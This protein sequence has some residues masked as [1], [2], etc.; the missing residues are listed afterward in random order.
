MSVIVEMNNSP[1]S[2]V[3]L[4]TALDASGASSSSPGSASQHSVPSNHPTP[5]NHSTPTSQRRFTQ[6]PSHQSSA[7]SEYVDSPRVFGSPL[8]ALHQ[9]SNPRDGGSPA[10]DDSS[11]L[12]YLRASPVTSSFQPAHSQGILPSASS[13]PGL[14]GSRRTLSGDSYPAESA[15]DSSQIEAG[16]STAPIRDGDIPR[17]RPRRR[18]SPLNLGHKDHSSGSGT[19]EEGTGQSRN[20][21]EH[22]SMSARTM[23]SDGGERVLR[24][25]DLLHS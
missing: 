21:L 7:S 3:T 9:T 2:Y 13:P 23:L 20:K 8:A 6:S 25:T 16:P 17:P 5:Q 14:S 1:Q 11:G 10:S 15:V 19:A 24:P 12:P 4:P 22:P 18:H